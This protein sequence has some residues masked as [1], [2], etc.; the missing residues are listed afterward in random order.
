MWRTAALVLLLAWVLAGCSLEGSGSAAPAAAPQAPAAKLRLLEETFA[1]P[2]MF[3]AS[4]LAAVSKVLPIVAVRPS[5][6]LAPHGSIYSVWLGDARPSGARDATVIWKSGVV[7]TFE[8][9]SCNCTAGPSLRQMG[10]RKPFRFLVLRGAPAIT[11]P[12]DP[13]ANTAFRIGPVPPAGMKF[14]IPASVETIRDGYNITLWEYGPNVQDGLLAAARTLPVEHLAL[15]P[16][17]YAAGGAALGNWSG[18]HGIDVAP[19][20]GAEFGIGVGLENV[21]GRPL[22]IT[23]VNAINGFIHL[24]GVHLWRPNAWGSLQL[25]YLIENPCISWSSPLYDAAVE[26]V[27]TQDGVS[28]IQAIPMVRLNITG[29]G[30][31]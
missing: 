24:I 5:S 4:S 6:P 10:H 26:V 1:N 9:W 2:R 7:E 21:S 27:Y 31:C 25:D 14:G 12:S 11:A 19:R 16:G 17:G 22:T 23:G 15:H 18:R 30:S 20:G 13:N 29:A 28:H 8:R 3:R